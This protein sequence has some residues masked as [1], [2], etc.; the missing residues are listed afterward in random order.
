MSTQ[1]TNPQKAICN[2]TIMIRHEMSQVAEKTWPPMVRRRPNRTDVGPASAQNNP[3]PEHA[4]STIKSLLKNTRDSYITIYTSNIIPKLVRYQN[5]IKSLPQFTPDGVTALWYR[6]RKS[7]SNVLVNK[8]PQI[9]KITC[10]STKYGIIAR[11][12]NIGFSHALSEQCVHPHSNLP[13]TAFILLRYAYRSMPYILL[14]TGTNK[15]N[16]GYQ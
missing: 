11:N 1:C 16:S 6:S 12:Q 5:N 14:S 13:L 4:I 10:L 15:H 9:R 7:I 2:T 3:P 8:V